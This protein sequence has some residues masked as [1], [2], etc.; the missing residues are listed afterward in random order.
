MNFWREVWEGIR[1]PCRDSFYKNF[2]LTM[3]PV[4]IA[5]F[6]MDYVKTA[7]TRELI[8]VFA[9]VGAYHMGANWGDPV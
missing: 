9:V 7:S 6:A 2:G 3:I 4:L 8:V 5:G 1:H